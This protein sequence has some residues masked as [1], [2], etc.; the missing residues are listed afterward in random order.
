MRLQKKTR[1]I[2]GAK[3]LLHQKYYVLLLSKCW[4]Y[5]SW[6]KLMP[7]ISHL[8][9]IIDISIGPLL[10][11]ALNLTCIDRVQCSSENEEIMV[12]VLDS[13]I[14]PILGLFVISGAGSFKLLLF[15]DVAQMSLS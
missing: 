5:I 6:S 11:W 12:A 7:L 1:F 9:N 15:E 14:V 3:S 10:W 2:D 4:F 13:T 8:I